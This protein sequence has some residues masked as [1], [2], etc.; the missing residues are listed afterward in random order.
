MKRIIPHPILSITLFISWLLLNNTVAAGHMVLGTILSILIPWLTSSFWQEKVCAKNPT[1]FLK[2]V[3]V[4]LYDIVMANITVAKQILGPNEYL[5]PTF[6]KLPIK[7]EDP[8]AI[9]VLAS[10]ISL[11][12]GTVSCDLS[13]D[14]SYLLIHGLSI[15][16]IE[17]E[18]EI[19]QQRY[20]KPLLE[21]FQKC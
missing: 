10:T 21:I 6:F 3:I 20:E 17:K 18:I 16:D 5:K 14:R 15:E 1:V 19:I 12:P 13:K 2:L 11:T 8:L 9:S 7:L 4:V